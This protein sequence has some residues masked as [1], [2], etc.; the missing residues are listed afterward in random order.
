MRS[1]AHI[2]TPDAT[3]FLFKLCKHFAKKIPVEFDETRGRA[4]FP[5]GVCELAATATTL[6]FAC[7]ASAAT[8][9]QMQ[10]VLEQHLA[11]M[12][13]RDPLPVVWT[14]LD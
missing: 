12:T 1:I 2:T 13:R 8:L 7:E 9:A 3:K 6:T 5:F 4:E 11:L 10:S 14:A